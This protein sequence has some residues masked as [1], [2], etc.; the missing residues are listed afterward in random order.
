MAD[1]KTSKKQYLIKVSV[2]LETLISSYQENVGLE[3]GKQL[4]SVK[5][6]ILSSTNWM[7]QDGIQATEVEEI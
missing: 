2:D 6:L 5:D 3:N 4:P 7:D 1:S